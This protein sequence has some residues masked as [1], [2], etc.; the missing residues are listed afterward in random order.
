MSEPVDRRVYYEQ[1]LNERIRAF[2][3]LEHLFGR[4]ARAVDD[5]DPWASRITVESIIDVMALVGRSDLK[6]ELVK[7][8]ERHAATLT[9]LARN[10]RVDPGRLETVLARLQDLLEPLRASDNA[11]GQELR[12]HELLAAVRQRNAIPAGTCDFDL[13][14]FH[15]WLERPPERRAEDLRRWLGSFDSL[16]DAVGL[17]LWLTRDSAEATREIADAGFFQ[18]SLE[19]S[20]PCQML[21]VSVPASLELFPEISA[22]KHRFTVR[23]MVPGEGDARPVQSEEDVPF[24]LLCCNL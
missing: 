10:P 9:A 3:R 21:R 19:T 23:F 1:P 20:T 6:K 2:L 18:R 7:E 16:R 12:G 24:E 17:C 11:L 13:P 8:L 4:A 22:G 15:Y 14:V 5:P